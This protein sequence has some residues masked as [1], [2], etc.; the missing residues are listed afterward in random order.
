MERWNLHLKRMHDIQKEKDVKEKKKRS[1]KEI[2]EGIFNDRQR[3]PNLSC[4]ERGW[5]L[6]APERNRLTFH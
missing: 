6:R 2:F 4:E 3:R 5:I 1:K